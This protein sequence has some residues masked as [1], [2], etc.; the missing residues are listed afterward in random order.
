MWLISHKKQ[1]KPRSEECFL[2]APQAEQK[3]NTKQEQKKN[4]RKTV[5]TEQERKNDEHVKDLLS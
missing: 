4:I 2:S 3:K 5:N 1:N